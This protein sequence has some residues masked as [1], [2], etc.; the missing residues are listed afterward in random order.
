MP[1]VGLAQLSRDKIREEAEMLASKPLLVTREDQQL[2]R[3]SHKR[4]PVAEANDRAMAEWRLNH[5]EDV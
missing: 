5:S 2:H 1:Q 3:R 4:L